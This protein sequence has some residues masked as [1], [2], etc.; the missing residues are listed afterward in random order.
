MNGNLTVNGNGHQ[1]Y[2]VTSKN[3]DTNINGHA[4][5]NSSNST[6]KSI[7]KFGQKSK[8]Q[9]LKMATNGNGTSFEEQ[10]ENSFVDVTRR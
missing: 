9:L 2:N 8:P 10:T 1:N 7:N 4:S 6:E 5:A 3:N